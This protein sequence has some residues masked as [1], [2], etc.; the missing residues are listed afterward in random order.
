MNKKII[1]ILFITLILQA[2]L[3]FASTENPDDYSSGDFQTGTPFRQGV[4]WDASFALGYRFSGGKSM[5]TRART[6]ILIVREPVFLSLGPFFDVHFSE[7]HQFGLQGEFMHL[8]S[9]TWAQAGIFKELEGDAGFLASIGWS[10]FGVE[11]QNKFS[12]TTE[13]NWN[14]ALKIRIPIGVYAFGTQN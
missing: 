4:S 3:S 5:F 7:N 11:Y 10:V 8:W 12:S 14:L 6:G 2:P 1:Y 9:G 13:D